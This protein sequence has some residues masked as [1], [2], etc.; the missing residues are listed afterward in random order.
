MVRKSQTE[1]RCR[2]PPETV[3]RGSCGFGES[4]A[5]CACA[6]GA[7]CALADGAAPGAAAIVVAG[8]SVLFAGALF[9]VSR[10]DGLAACDVCESA[11]SSAPAPCHSGFAK[12]VNNATRAAN[13]TTTTIRPISVIALCPAVAMAPR[14]VP[15]M[16]QIRTL[17]AGPDL[18][19]WTKEPLVPN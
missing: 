17:S 18:R 16:E 1:F 12:M 10:S 7:C 13:V 3:L 11:F 14:C 6:G 19:L 5:C 4:D 2:L 8:T 15:A 9:A